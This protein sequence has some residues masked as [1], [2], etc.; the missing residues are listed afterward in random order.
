[1]NILDITNIFKVFPIGFR[2]ISETFII[3]VNFK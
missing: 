1:M 2:V 3:P